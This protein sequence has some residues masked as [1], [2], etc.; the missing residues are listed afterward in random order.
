MDVRSPGRP[1]LRE[2]RRQPSAD[3]RATASPSPLHPGCI[4]TRPTPRVWSEADR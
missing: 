1:S 2:A 4:R 3:I